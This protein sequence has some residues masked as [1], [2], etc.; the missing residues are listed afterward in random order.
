M[1][2]FFRA[3]PANFYRLLGS[4]RSTEIAR[5]LIVSLA[6]MILMIIL[7]NGVLDITRV[8]HPVARVAAFFGDREAEKHI[9]GAVSAPPA[10]TP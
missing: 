6:G 3:L 8:V 10:E 2:R 4:H 9:P 7:M 5:L 1:H